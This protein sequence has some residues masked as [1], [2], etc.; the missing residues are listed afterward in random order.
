MMKTRTP[1]SSDKQHARIPRSSSSGRESESTMEATSSSAFHL[2]STVQ[3]PPLHRYKCICVY[4]AGYGSWEGCHHLQHPQFAPPP[5]LMTVMK[6]QTNHVD[7]NDDSDDDGSDN[8]D[9]D[10]DA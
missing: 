9:D 7:V 1:S 2:H 8:D 3:E 4:V 5:P 10:N 6:K